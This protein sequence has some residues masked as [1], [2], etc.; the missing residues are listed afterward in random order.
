MD[1]E[2]LIKNIKFWNWQAYRDNHT[3][4]NGKSQ[5]FLLK[6]VLI[7]GIKEN[8]NI[9]I[10][11]KNKHK[12]SKKTIKK[13]FGLLLPKDFYWNEY[14]S[15]YS[16]L[17]YMNENDAKCHYIFHGNYEGRNYKCEIKREVR[18]LPF[19]DYN[20][21]YENVLIIDSIFGLGNRLRAIASAYSICIKKNMK[22]IINWIPDDHC[23]CL[24]EDLIVNINEYAEVVS[25]PINIDSLV[26]FKIY[27]YLETERGGEKNEYID[28]NVNKIYV[29]SN[30]V[31]NNKDSRLYSNEFLQSLKW[32]DDINHLINSIPDIS[33]YTGMHI[34]MEG[35]AQYTSQTYEKTSNWINKETEL[36]F[37]YREISH[38]D[39]FINQINNILHKNPEQKFFIATDMKSNYE[40]LIN[41]YGNDKIK[42]LER[43]NFDRSKEQL[44]YAVADIILL[45]R[46]NQF[47]GSTWSSFSELITHFQ[48]EEIK[49][50]NVFSNT[51]KIQ[52]LSKKVNFFN[53]E[54]KLGNSI[55]CVSM[56]RSENILKS[57][58]SWL[59]INNCHEIVI[60]DY[61][62]KEK[63]SGILKSHNFNDPKI[64][65]FRVENVYKWHLAKA[66]NLAI[67]LS[68]YKNIY[69]LDSDDICSS[70]LIDNYPLNESNI[71]YHGRWQDARDKNELQIAGKMFF[72]YDMFVDC[73]GYNENITTYGWDDCD[74]NL[75]LDKIG[76]QIPININDFNFIEHDDSIRQEKN[77]QNITPNQHIHINR[78]LC[79]KNILNW[80]KKSLHGEFVNDTENSFKLIES[81]HL[82]YDFINKDTL[83]KVFNLVNKDGTKE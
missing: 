47:Y 45:S 78:I 33:N 31:L 7:K 38:I 8:R 34:R 21:N 65:I 20:N 62:S 80:N 23:D 42:I 57:L 61:G 48:K 59:K 16:D 43:N 76:I 56:N 77:E 81:S 71:Y 60:L 17:Q 52:N 37:K 9:V 51:F 83:N 12:I 58:P 50:S 27:N 67:K 25:N 72:T 30:C 18:Q 22:L 5:I 13:N 19:I 82:T 44:Y 39:N 10:D 11:K 1:Q 70:N 46:C 3:D 73:N 29:K 32:S 41:I 66:Y 14:I 4:L 28:D 36:L 6:H 79:E 40:K 24:I 49:K 35:G 53:Q 68:S 15:L 64:K 69:K 54:L 2:N 55:V 26:D 63:L 75:R 74:F